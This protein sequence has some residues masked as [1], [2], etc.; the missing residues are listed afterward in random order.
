MLLHSTVAGFNCAGFNFSWTQLLLDLAFAGFTF[1]GFNVCWTQVCWI[2][3]LLGSAFPGLNSFLVSFT[4]FCWIIELCWFQNLLA[5][6]CWTQCFA[7]CILMTASTSAVHGAVFHDSHHFSSTWNSLG[8]PSFMTAIIFSTSLAALRV[9]FAHWFCWIF[10]SVLF[11]LLVSAILSN[12]SFIKPPSLLSGFPASSFHK[13]MHL[14]CVSRVVQTRVFLFL[15]A[16]NN[17]GASICTG[18]HRI[19]NF[20]ILK[21]SECTQFILATKGIEQQRGSEFQP[22]LFHCIQ[23]SVLRTGVNA[24]CI[25]ECAK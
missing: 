1:A 9:I 4:H 6:F 25:E 3:V 8:W 15:Q 13:C 7:G 20:S 12:I 24:E 17:N 11:T 14:M 5:S 18:I 23:E 19:M 2:Q 16:V 10:L 22:V 21:I